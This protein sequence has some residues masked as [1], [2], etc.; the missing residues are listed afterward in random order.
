MEVLLVS[1]KGSYQHHQLL[2]NFYKNCD[3]WKESFMMQIEEYVLDIVKIYYHKKYNKKV[4]EEIAFALSFYAAGTMRVYQQWI[5]SANPLTPAEMAE[6][7]DQC[8]PECLR[9]AL[10]GGNEI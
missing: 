10:D 6:K 2:R 5:C 3:W 9:E 1:G 4:P 7:I 8:V